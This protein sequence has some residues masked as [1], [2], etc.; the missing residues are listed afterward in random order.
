MPG[1][2]QLLPAWTPAVTNSSAGP[3]HHPGQPERNF[4]LIASAGL[5]DV[6]GVYAYRN[7]I[8][9]SQGG[10][11]R[12]QGQEV[13]TR[14]VVAGPGFQAQLQS[15]LQRASGV[16]SAEALA[17][18][19]RRILADQ[20]TTPST[21]TGALALAASASGCAASTKRWSAHASWELV[22]RLDAVLP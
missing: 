13:L 20:L 8:T 10:L 14:D 7:A 5:H 22:P 1:P 16:R 3:H 6:F 19:W 18:Y 9:P 4:K 21:S 2:A 15:D 11:R 12:D 17:Y